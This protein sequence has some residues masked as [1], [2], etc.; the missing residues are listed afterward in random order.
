MN[1]NIFSNDEEREFLSRD[2][3]ETLQIK[4]LKQQLE[5][6][7]NVEFYKNNIPN[8]ENISDE[9]NSLDD[10]KKL[11]FT[12][13]QDL[14]DN[15]PL[16]F[17]AIQKSEVA[18][19]HGSSGTTGKPT[20]VPYSK[21][22][23]KTWAS[24]CSRFLKAGG[25]KPEYT[26]QIAFGYGLFTGGFGLHYGME[27]LGASVIP[28]SSGN[29]PRQIAIMQDMKPEVLICTPS[30]ALN[31]ADTA[32]QMGITP[33]S[34]PIKIGHFGGE[35][36]TEEMRTTIEEKLGI[37]AFNNYGLSEVI[38][39]GIS[40]ECHLQDGMHI[41]EDHFIVEC[42][43]PQTL[44]PVPEGE[45]G[46]L[47]F[48]S[49]TKEAMPIIRYRTRDIASITKKVCPCGRTTAKMSRV[50]GRSDDMF[51]IKGVNV[52]PSQ[53]EEA[54][55]RVEGTAPHYIILIDRPKNL[56]QVTIKVEI[57]S[58]DFSDKMRDM[59]GLKENIDRAIQ[60]V[61]NIR[62]NIELVEPGTLERSN[63]K[64]VR[65]IDNR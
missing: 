25:V 55:L 13:K 23:L 26:A 15:Y 1:N 20:F 17:L 30:Y 49:L 2:E 27:E 12:T 5:K 4:R 44:E 3:I 52:Y 60:S 37:K 58:Q 50:I 29:T 8:I 19:F 57:R 34:L 42:V 14:R 56:D 24:L 46:E 33:S 59:Q 28:T 22:D 10:L 51:I 64:A 21:N 11:P 41:Q 45:P 32:E 9:I 61:A 65:L 16:G 35:M 43:D 36:W 31:I 53:I 62:A 39:P 54:L 38:G 48:T 7:K 63:G 6:V 47:I 18:R 40:G